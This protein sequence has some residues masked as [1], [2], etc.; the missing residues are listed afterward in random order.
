MLR[1]IATASQAPTPAPPTEGP[2]ELP[3]ASDRTLARMGIAPNSIL[4]PGVPDRR[5][6]T[7]STEPYTGAPRGRPLGSVKRSRRGR[8]PSS[9]VV[10]RAEISEAGNT[11][12]LVTTGGASMLLNLQNCCFVVAVLLLVNVLTYFLIIIFC[13]S[14]FDNYLYLFLLVV[15]AAGLIFCA[16]G[17]KC[18]C[19]CVGRKR[20]M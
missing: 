9:Y 10:P 12:S 16:K 11:A 14:L 19:V 20:E 7:P 15:L 8:R 18:V 5:P 4:L 17:C 6:Y 3:T 2:P 1:R 13:L